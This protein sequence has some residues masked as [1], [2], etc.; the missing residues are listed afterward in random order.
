[1]LRDQTVCQLA[2][3]V[4][5]SSWSPKTAVTQTGK[6]G[7]KSDWSDLFRYTQSAYQIH[8]CFR[9]PTSH[10]CYN[11]LL[12]CEYN[13]KEKLRER[14]LTS[15]GN[16]EGFGMI[17]NTKFG[18][19]AMSIWKGN[20]WLTLYTRGCA[21]TIYNHKKKECPITKTGQMPFLANH[22]TLPGVLL[23]RCLPPCAKISVSANSQK[24][25]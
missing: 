9:L 12:L 24:L 16:A 7:R 20:T 14:L 19:A 25:V 13:S 18:S 11:V 22:H 10:T 8:Y 15:I 1:L 2:D 4:N 6:R 17:W 21:T 3:W 5:C 23:A